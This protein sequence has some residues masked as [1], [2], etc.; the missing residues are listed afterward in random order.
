MKWTAML[1]ALTLFVN[2][3]SL[4]DKRSESGQNTIAKT[5]D[6][7]RHADAARLVEASG[8]KQRLQDNFEQMVDEGVRQLMDKC[9][10]CTPAFGV[11]WKKRFIERSNLQ[12]YVDVYVRAYEKYFT[13]SEINELISWGKD[14]G[15]AKAVSRSPALKEKLTLVTPSIRREAVSESEQIGAK[16]GEQIGNEIEREHPE[17]MKPPAK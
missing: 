4:V 12:D 14:K 6:P 11:E 9:Q 17:Y 13:D 2:A 1:F 7:A 3:Q 8:A 10:R 15:T 5:V 16:L